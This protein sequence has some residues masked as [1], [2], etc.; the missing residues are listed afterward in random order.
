MGEGIFPASLGVPERGTPGLGGAESFLPAV[1]LVQGWVRSGLSIYAPDDL[2]RYID[3]GAD[4]YLSYHFEM[5]YSAEYV[6]NLQDESEGYVIVDVYQMRDS[7]SAFGVYSRS[8]SPRYTP[9]AVGC[10]GYQEGSLV[11]FYRDRYQVRVESREGRG[12]P[13]QAALAFAWAV[14]ERL[15]GPGCV[16]EAAIFPPS[17]VV[18]LS[19]RYSPRDPLGTDSLP[20]GFVATLRGGKAQV[21]VYFFGDGDEAEAALRELVRFFSA[22]PLEQ[23]PFPAYQGMDGRGRSVLFALVSGR[24]VGLR[25]TFSEGDRRL[26]LDAL[27][28]LRRR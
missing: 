16:D 8:R 12:E 15:G 14:E 5:L 1:G 10:S 17:L 26:F 25:G 22:R 24:L 23:K 28:K 21:L 9:A 3:G 27:D 20:G 18:P 2:W 19:V 13:E 6:R 7:L 4:L 11:C